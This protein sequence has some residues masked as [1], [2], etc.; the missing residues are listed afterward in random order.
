MADRKRLQQI[1]ANF[2][3]NAAKFS[4][5]DGEIR[6]AARRTPEGRVALSVADQGPGIPD[7]F[8]TRIFGKFEQ[9]KHD[10]GGTGLGLAICKALVERMGGRIG[11][12]SAPGKGATFFVELPAA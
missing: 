10:K 6:I 2:I 3:S 8:K 4:P 9:A 1:V 7:E 11:C 12:D 5:K